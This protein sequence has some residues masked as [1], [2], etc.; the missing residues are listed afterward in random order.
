MFF[1]KALHV[2]SNPMS[3][4]FVL[5]DLALDSLGFLAC[6]KLQRSWLA[7]KGWLLADD[8]RSLLFSTIICQE[9]GSNPYCRSAPM[10]SATCRLTFAWRG[11]SNLH[12][13]RFLMSSIVTFCLNMLF[14]LANSV[15]SF[16]WTSENF[17]RRSCSGSMLLPV[18]NRWNIWRK[19][20]SSKLSLVK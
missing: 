11:V 14:V 6:D 12:S 15:M 7:V 17:A 20:F 10:K 5:E 19:S 3:S 8:E 4:I 1:T 16:I 18:L 13:N 2:A 9:K